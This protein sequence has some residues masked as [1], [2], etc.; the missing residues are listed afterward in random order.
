MILSYE[1]K[2]KIKNGFESLNKCMITVC[3]RTFKD[4]IRYEEDRD[5]SLVDIR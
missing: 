1:E 5:L 2:K 3:I 4:L